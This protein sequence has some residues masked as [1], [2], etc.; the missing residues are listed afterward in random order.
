MHIEN[1]ILQEAVYVPSPHC[2]DRP[3]DTQVNLLVIHNISLPPGQFGGPFIEQL[4]TG[5]LNPEDHVYF[6]QIY[7]MRVSAHFLIRRDGTIV[8]FVPLEKRAWHAGLSSFQ[9][10]DN[11]NDYSIGIELEG[12]DTIGYTKQ[13]YSALTNLSHTIRQVY[14]EITLGRIVGHQDIAPVRKTDPGVSFDWAYFRTRLV[15]K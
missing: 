9:G 13:Q 12:T 11:C 5:K 3:A 6:R 1:G 2:N 14:P 4:F 7:Q 10:Q 15:N 8:Q